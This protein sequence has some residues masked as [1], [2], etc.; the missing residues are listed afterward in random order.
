MYNGD[1][2]ATCCNKLLLCYYRENRV[3]IVYYACMSM[4]TQEDVTELKK[5]GGE[6]GHAKFGDQHNNQLVTL[7]LDSRPKLNMAQL[8]EGP[9]LSLWLVLVQT[10]PRS[11]FLLLLHITPFLPKRKY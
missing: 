8:L 6:I 5:K 1:G 2:F 4:M 9:G 10:G 3:K 7:H 11:P